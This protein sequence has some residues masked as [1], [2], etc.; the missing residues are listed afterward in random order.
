MEVFE[1]RREGIPLFDPI[2][3]IEWRR[4]DEDFWMSEEQSDEFFYFSEVNETSDNF[5]AVLIFWFFCIKTKECIN[6]ILSMD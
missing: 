4:M 2:D 5:S 1:C 6:K 3:E